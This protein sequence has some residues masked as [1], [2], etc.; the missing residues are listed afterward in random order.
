MSSGFVGDSS[1]TTQMSPRSAGS[2]STLHSLMNVQQ[3]A[4]LGATGLL[5]EYQWPPSP[6]QV[7]DRFPD[8]PFSCGAGGVDYMKKA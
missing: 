6:G 4:L 7:R 1:W 2:H 5:R 8:P 3:G